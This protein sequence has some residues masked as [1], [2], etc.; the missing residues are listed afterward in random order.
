MRQRDPNWLVKAIIWC[1]VISR[2]GDNKSATLKEAMKPVKEF[3]QTL[4][5]KYAKEKQ[6][7]DSF[8]CSAKQSAKSKPTASDVFVDTPPSEPQRSRKEINDATTEKIADLLSHNPWGLLLFAEELAG[9]LGGMDAYRARGGKD[10][11]FWLQAKDGG[12]FTVDRKTSGSIFVPNCA[13]SV[14][15]SIQDDKIKKIARG[16][17]DDGFLQ[18]FLSIFL[19]RT[20]DGEDIAP[21]VDLDQQMKEI[22]IEIGSIAETATF[23]FAA[24]ADCELKAVQAFVT[25][26]KARPGASQAFCEWL[27][28]MPNEFGRLALIFHH[29]EWASIAGGQP[30]VLVPRETAAR[31]RR[32]LTEFVCGHA[33]ALYSRIAGAGEDDDR[34]KWI[35]GFILARSRDSVDE[36]DI[37]RSYGE[38][39]SREKRDDIPAVM[40]ILEMLD[41]V[42]PAAWRPNGN[43]KRWLA[44]PMVHDGRF[45]AVA[46]AERLRRAEVP[47]LIAAAAES[48]NSQ[49]SVR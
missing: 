18:R 26:E 25:A 39:K 4:K 3:E 2:S 34:A 7:F 45:S 19:K 29:I 31:A 41:W 14:L 11:P 23:R 36:R 9:M 35:A 24:D 6:K 49:G 13:V 15:G 8:Q 22:A 21:D 12:T 37:Y 20:G 44:N 1:M 46:E 5:S 48:R 16:L 38:L 43:A 30:P 33:R 40:R 27:N 42:R 28:K 32:F 10:R 47:K 17:T